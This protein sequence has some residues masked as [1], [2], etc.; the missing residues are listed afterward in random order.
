MLGVAIVQIPGARN[1]H[2]SAGAPIKESHASFYVPRSLE[3]WTRGV[4]RAAAEGVLRRRS[5]TYEGIEE[6]LLRE[7]PARHA[8]LGLAAALGAC[9][10]SALGSVYFEKILKEAST[11]NGTPRVGIWIRN[12]QLSVY[13][14]FPA[15]FIGVVFVDGEAIAR[16]GFFAGYNEVVWTVVACQ[17]LGGILVAL[18]V[19]Y[20]DNIAKSFATSISILLSLCVSIVLFDFTM[21][22]YVRPF[23]PPSR[24]VA[25]L[26]DIYM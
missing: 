15:F 20:A 16:A 22:R 9:T 18:C 23:P 21:T 1:P 24:Y 4:G 25:I 12:V 11:G 3:A 19:H 26:A 13:A 8:A 2:N 5:A 6:D 14:L 17:A 10:V 7:H